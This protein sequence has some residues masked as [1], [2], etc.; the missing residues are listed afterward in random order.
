MYV[1]ITVKASEKENDSKDRQTHTHTH[2]HTRTHF[3]VEEPPDARVCECIRHFGN[4]FIFYRLANKYSHLRCRYLL[5]MFKNDTPNMYSQILVILMID[6]KI[7]VHYVRLVCVEKIL[8]MIV[9]I[10]AH[11]CRMSSWYWARIKIICVCGHHD[12]R[13]SSFFFAIFDQI[14]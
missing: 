1:Q 3:G 6:G 9:F 13:F 12:K 14:I 11:L 2:G 4:F 5:S 10:V 7:N 8:L